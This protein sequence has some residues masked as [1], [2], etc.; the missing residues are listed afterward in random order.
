[1]QKTLKKTF[2]SAE[3]VLAFDSLSHKS[4]Q[5]AQQKIYWAR[6]LPQVSLILEA[7]LFSGCQLVRIA[8]VKVFSKQ[9]WNIT[10]IRS[11]AAPTAQPTRGCPRPRAPVSSVPDEAEASGSPAQFP[12]PAQLEIGRAHV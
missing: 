12:A 4:S 11:Y 2:L 9:R 5:L 10:K 8:L 1:M 6:S 3:V 7:V